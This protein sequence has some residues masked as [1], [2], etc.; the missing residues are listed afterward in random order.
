MMARYG[1]SDRNNCN[2]YYFVSE[3]KHVALLELF[4][5]EDTPRAT[6]SVQ[7]S[8]AFSTRKRVFLNGR[9]DR[10]NGPEDA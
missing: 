7:S 2:V 9:N 1:N 4:I 5:N 3:L 6:N 10:L 8:I